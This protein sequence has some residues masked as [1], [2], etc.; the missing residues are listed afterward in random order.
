MKWPLWVQLTAWREFPGC[1]A[2]RENLLRAWISCSGEET[3]FR[4]WGGWNGCSFPGTVLESK[5]L[6]RELLRPQR[7]FP[8]SHQLSYDRHIRV[9][10]TWGPRKNPWRGERWPSPWSSQ[11]ACN[12]SCSPQSVWRDLLTLGIEQSPQ[13]GNQNDPRLTAVLDSLMNSKASFEQIKLFP[14]YLTIF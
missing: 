3:E 1:S 12:S 2:G 4:V 6:Y 14:S 9:E 5:E 11:E 10:A 7:D 13:W 8:M